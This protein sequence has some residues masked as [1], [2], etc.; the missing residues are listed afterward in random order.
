MRYLHWSYYGLQG[1]FNLPFGDKGVLLSTSAAAVLGIMGTA[2]ASV[3][4]YMFVKRAGAVF[5]LWLLM[6]YLLLP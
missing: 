4:F 6:A 3:I 5:V 2:V 1:Y